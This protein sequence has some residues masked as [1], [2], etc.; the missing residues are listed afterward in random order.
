MRCLPLTT[1]PPHL[2]IT[3]SSP[4]LPRPRRRRSTSRSRVGRVCD[5]SASPLSFCRRPSRHRPLHQAASAAVETQAA[6]M[7][8]EEV[9]A[10]EERT[11]P[12]PAT[13]GG[14]GG[15]RP[16]TRS[17]SSCSYSSSPAPRP[18]SPKLSAPQEMTRGESGR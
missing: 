11:L 18:C 10:A 4:H 13:G 15:S 1:P 6:T 2:P 8:E 17:S 5:S 12:T 16:S 14:V 3:T 7:E 9:K